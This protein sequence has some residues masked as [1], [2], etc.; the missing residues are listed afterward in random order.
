MQQI[1]K[2]VKIWQSYREF[3]DG[4]FLRH[5]VEFEYGGRLF[6]ETVS[7]NI[8]AVCWRYII[9]IRYTQSFRRSWMCHV[10]KLETASKSATL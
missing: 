1:W 10:T 5:S 8:S 9:E 4:N 2:S 7:S 6:S 3:K